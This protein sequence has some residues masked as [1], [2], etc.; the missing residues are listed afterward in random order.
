M[1]RQGASERAHM[2]QTNFFVS[3]HLPL[4]LQSNNFV[5][6]FIF[7]AAS[8]AAAAALV[9]ALLAL[10]LIKLRLI[11]VNQI[12]IYTDNTN[13]YS[14]TRTSHAHNSFVS[15]QWLFCILFHS[16]PKTN[17]RIKAISSIA[18]TK[19]IIGLTNK[20]HILKHILYTFWLSNNYHWR[21]IVSM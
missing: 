15:D 1:I 19:P 5:R 8:A 16:A 3:L 4:T 6:D 10:R 2:E 18:A 13:M 14:Q 11:A 21:C 17:A 9:I 20:L 12:V 7:I